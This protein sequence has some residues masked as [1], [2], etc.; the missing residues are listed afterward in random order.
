MCIEPQTVDKQPH[1]PR[2]NLAFL[3][4]SHSWVYPGGLPYERN[5]DARR[6]CW[7][8]HLKEANLGVARAFF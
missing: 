5:A 1:I 3:S 4:H 8:K 6:K 2:Q 7:I